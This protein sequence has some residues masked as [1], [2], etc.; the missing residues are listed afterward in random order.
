MESDLYE[1]PFLEV[2]SG[3]LAGQS[4]PLTGREVTIG[5]G[6]GNDIVIADDMVSLRHA[7]ITRRPEAI[8]IDDLDS[9]NG[10]IVNGIRVDSHML[11]PGDHIL[12][13]S[14]ELIF[15]VK[16]YL[17]YPKPWRKDMKKSLP[18][19]LG[20]TA[21]VAVLIIA[22]L[23]VLLVLRGREKAQDNV[24]PEVE[25]VK[26]ADGARYEL[27]FAPGSKVDVEI[28]IEA[29]DDRELNKVDLL[30]DGEKVATF[31]AE[32]GP[33]YKYTLT[34][35]EPKTYSLRAKAFDAT[36]NESSSEAIT[37]EVWTDTARKSQMENYVF[38]VDK[39]ILEYR[40]IRQ[41]FESAYNRGLSMGPFDPQWYSLAETFYVARESFTNLRG[42]LATYSV[43]QEFEAA[44]I[45]LTDMFTASIQACN[46]AAEWA[47]S[48]GASDTARRNMVSYD[49]QSRIYGSNF[50]GSYDQARMQYLGMG[51]SIS[52]F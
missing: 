1:T 18:L 6:P 2:A 50:R 21:S 47:A 25:L 27:S 33:P 39:L 23:V 52:P 51:P 9:T 17:G 43:P 28:L 40:R 10:T 26:P 14:T 22:L 15:K 19:L 13:G 35:S 3:P 42:E 34:A 12:L 7:R 41:E 24:P 48:G 44:H 45:K 11:K 30:V 37:V 38:Q 29:S 31:R 16:G 36:G 4:F 46:Y 49:S 20:T 5:R 8:I 32:E